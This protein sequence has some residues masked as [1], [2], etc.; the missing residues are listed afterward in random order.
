[1]REMFGSQRLIYASN[2]PVSGRFAPVATVQGIIADYF[3]SPGRRAEEQ[4]YVQSAKVVYRCVERGKSSGM[5]KIKKTLPEP[6][7]NITNLHMASLN[8][9]SA[10]GGY[11]SRHH[12]SPCWPAAGAR[13]WR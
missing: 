5:A 3:R 7:R 4:V 6:V 12:A 13:L 11:A 9:H 10:T 1:M 8:K 2:W